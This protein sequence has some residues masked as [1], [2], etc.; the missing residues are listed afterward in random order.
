MKKILLSLATVA[1][2]GSMAVAAE[3]TLLVNDATDIQGTDVPERPAGTNGETDKGQARHIQ[4]LQQLS[5]SGVSFTF[6]KGSS[7]T[8]PAYYY[9][10]STNADGD[11]T[12]RVYG[13]NTMSI[14]VPAGQEFTVIK[15]YEGTK[16]TVVYSGEK[17]ATYTYTAEATLKI[18]KFVLSDEAAPI[19]TKDKFTK[20]NTLETGSYVFVCDGKLATPEDA[21]K[22]YGRMPL[23]DLTLEGADVVTDAA[24]AFTITV[25]DG[26][27][28]I[29]DANNRY[30]SMDAEHLSTFQ[31]YDTLNEYSYWT[32]T[33]EGDNVKFVNAVN[34]NCIISQ[35]KGNSGTWYSNVAPA[36]EPT[37]FNLP[38]LYKKAG[39]SGIS[40]IGIDNEEAPVYYNLQGVRVENPSK[41]LYIVVKGNKSSKVIL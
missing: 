37:E 24:N 30:Y 33:F 26:K 28:T 17:A 38:I 14:T 13:G 3:T 34:T 32:Y 21:S 29:K 10:M 41:G 27:A 18:T 8:D 36:K 4:P 9:P 39:D 12:I 35:T 31:F 20:V 7:K 2:C 25:A 16:E 22:T 40:N 23:K 11:K 5:I 6:A 19:V 1:L 15:A